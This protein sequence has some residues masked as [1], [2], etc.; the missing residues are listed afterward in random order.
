MT[1]V[2][3]AGGAMGFNWLPVFAAIEQ[4]YFEEQGLKLELMRMGAVDKCTAAVAE[5]EA[6]LTITPPEGAVRSTVDGG[7]LRIIAGNVNVLPLSMVAHKRYSSLEEL[8]GARLGTSSLTEGTAIYTQA[9][10]ATHGLTY[11]GDYEFEVV[12]VHPA[13]WAALKEGRID[14]AVQLIPLNFVAFDEGW[15]NL[16]EVSDYIPEIVFTA[17][18]G[19]TQWLAANRDTATGFLRALSRGVDYV[20]D[21]ANES[22]L[23]PLVTEAT[24]AEGDYVR[25]SLEYMRDKGVFAQKLEIPPAAFAKTIELM[26]DARLLREEEVAKAQET[27]D[28]RYREAALA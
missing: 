18:I 14:A 15:S 8:R 28:L 5:G 19:D 20:S 26:H 2:K 25:K 9:M 21:P 13:R 11:P 22:A 24:K 6:D 12:G 4:G 27:I 3:L 1:E 16:G 17:L 10:L 7:P 23:M